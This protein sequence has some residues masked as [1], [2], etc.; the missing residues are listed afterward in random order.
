[1]HRP[2]G[3]LNSSNREIQMRGWWWHCGQGVTAVWP[4]TVAT[5]WLLAANTT[6]SDNASPITNEWL[7]YTLIFHFVV[8]SHLPYYNWCHSG[9]RSLTH[10]LGSLATWP[11]AVWCHPLRHLANSWCSPM[12]SLHAVYIRAVIISVSVSGS[13]QTILSHYHVVQCPSVVKRWFHRSHYLIIL[14]C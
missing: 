13:Y 12:A 5:L 3:G 14:L 6:L 4:L 1:M 7:L 8:V 11:C 10:D 2:A 9:Q